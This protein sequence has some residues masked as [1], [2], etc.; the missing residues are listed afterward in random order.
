MLRRHYGLFILALAAFLLIETPATAAPPLPVRIDSTT[1][2]PIGGD[3]RCPSEKEIS[4]N[5]TEWRSPSAYLGLFLWVG[6]AFHPPL[7]E[8]IVL[9]PSMV[10]SR[11]VRGC[12]CLRWAYEP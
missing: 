4:G 5:Q 6:P 7:N 3:K 10:R 9:N 8:W 12:Y 11:I 1:G 2:D